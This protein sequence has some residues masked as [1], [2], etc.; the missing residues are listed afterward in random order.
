MLTRRRGFLAGLSKD[1]LCYVSI[2]GGP[3][4]KGGDGQFAVSGPVDVMEAA[5]QGV[6]E[7][8][9]GKAGGKGTVQRGKGTGVSEGAAA[10]IA[11]LLRGLSTS[12]L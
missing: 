2:G 11:Q 7:R 3:G 8:V 5:V 10:D 4:A 6:C 9:N 1:V 12:Q